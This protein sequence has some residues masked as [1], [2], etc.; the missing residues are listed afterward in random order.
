ME[1]FSDV[2]RDRLAL[3]LGTNK[4]RVFAGMGFYVVL[5][6]NLAARMANAFLL[7]LYLLLF[8]TLIAMIEL[9]SF[10]ILIYPNTVRPNCSYKRNN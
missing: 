2:H 6:R 10:P 5:R 4:V 3:N 9:G 8:H 7:C 1:I